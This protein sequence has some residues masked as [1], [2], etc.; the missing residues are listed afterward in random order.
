MNVL[1]DFLVD[2]LGFTHH[3]PCMAEE[4]ELLKNLGG[5]DAECVELLKEK[6]LHAG[7]IRDAIKSGGWIHIGHFLQEKGYYGALRSLLHATQSR[8]VD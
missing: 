4:E 1:K 7:F 6:I 8:E 3:F 2:E 5:N